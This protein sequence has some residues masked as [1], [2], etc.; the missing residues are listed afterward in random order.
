AATFGKRAGYPKNLSAGRASGTGCP[1]PERP[2]GYDPRVGDPVPSGGSALRKDYGTA[3]KIKSRPGE[4][5]FKRS[6]TPVTIGCLC[7]SRGGGADI[8][9]KNHPLGGAD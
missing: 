7:G 1:H 3:D 4:L 2:G 9:G 8:A 5:A 6:G